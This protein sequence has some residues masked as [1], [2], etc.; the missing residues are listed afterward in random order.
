MSTQ[1]RKFAYGKN[2]IDGCPCPATA[3]G[4]S[5][6]GAVLQA[7]EWY[8]ST[9]V[10]LGYDNA[11]SVISEQEAKEAW[12]QMIDDFRQ[13]AERASDESNRII[14]ERIVERAIEIRDELGW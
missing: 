12:N 10:T 4:Y 13:H 2:S 6:D 11:H 14:Y 3:V 7:A 9:V 8:D 1:K 5:V